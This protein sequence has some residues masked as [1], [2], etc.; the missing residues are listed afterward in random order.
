MKRSKRITAFLCA[1]AL[2][3]GLTAAAADGEGE[4][5]ASGQAPS[6]NAA[7]SIA[8]FDSAQQRLLQMELVAENGGSRLYFDKN[9][10]DIGVVTEDGEAFFSSPSDLQR[11]TASSEDSKNRIASQLRI[12]Y[13]DTKKTESELLSYPECVATGQVTWEKISGGVRVNYVFGREEQR[14]LV[15]PALPAQSFEDNILAH[16]Q[17]RAATRMKAFYKKYDAQSTSQAQIEEIKSKYPAVEETPIYVL[18]SVTD[19]EKQEIEEYVKSTAY[20]FEQMEA[21]LKAVGATEEETD[22][23]YFAVTAQYTLE[24]GDF[25]AQ[26]PTDAISYDSSKY[27]LTHIGL[28]EYFAAPPVQNEGYLLIPDGS[29]AVMAFNRDGSKTGNTVSMPVYGYDRALSYLPGYES[30][31]QVRLPVFG[32]K[33]GE[34]GLLAV[35]EDGEALASINVSSGGNNSGYAN[36]G[37]VFAYADSDSF[38]FKDIGKQYAWTL[39]DSN[40]YTGDFQIRYRFL[41]SGRSDYSAMAEACRQYLTDRGRLPEEN[42]A[43]GGL[44]FYVG[45]YGSVKHQEQVLLFPVNRNIALTSFED[46]GQIVTDLQGKGVSDMKVRY[47]GWA[48][49]GLSHSAF[50]RAGVVSAL[51]GRKGLEQLKEKLDGMGIPLYLDADLAYVVNDGWFDGFSPSSQAGRK[52]DKTYASFEQKDLSSGLMDSATFRYA[53][54]PSVMA[55][56]FDKYAKAFLKMDVGSFSLGTLGGHLNSDKDAKRGENRQAARIAAEGILEKAAQYG[57]VMTESGNS[58]SYPYVSDIVALDSESS[59]YPDADY[60]VPFL[61]MV[62]HG[63]IRYSSKAI[64]LSGAPELELLKAV[65]NGAGL[66]FEVAYQ[67][68]E[69]LKNTAQKDLYSVDYRIWADTMADNYQKAAAAL[70]GLS[71]D[72]IVKHEYVQEGL[73]VVTYSSGAKVAVN[74]NREEKTVEGRTVKG[75]DFARIG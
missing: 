57:P 25:I 34:R 62:L 67:N 74:Y 69:K 49:G 46:A 26:V 71:G 14:L 48:N 4:D 40:R 35:I 45:L 9:T 39:A 44:D 12:Q 17:G 23:P 47:L 54:K 2:T 28:L 24:D 15:P 53:L 60:S 16:L 41:P 7:A 18:K 8:N 33:D 36:A 31:K 38:T 66:Y 59:G 10:C 43:G 21:D 56:F 72:T 6:Q 58:Y 75:M 1:C 61:Q 3:A 30:R 29:G 63:R 68:S 70:G 22:L 65:E 73:A 13:I 55:A 52:L 42:A 37:V 64:N 19:R 51:G 5:S 50:N 20:S 32:I 27:Q 11:D